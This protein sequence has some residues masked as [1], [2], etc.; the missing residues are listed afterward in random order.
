MKKLIKGNLISFINNYII[1]G[2][3]FEKAGVL[4]IFLIS[5]LGNFYICKFQKNDKD[6]IF[7]KISFKN[8]FIRGNNIEYDKKN[9]FAISS[10]KGEIIIFDI[11]KNFSNLLKNTN[12]EIITKFKIENNLSYDHNW[13]KMKFSKKENNP[14]I[15]CISNN[16]RKLIIFDY[17]KKIVF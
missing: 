3:F 13:V 14:K 4:R 2:F 7:Y 6:F 8:F 5:K 17:E 9:N 11:E 1:N 15:F 10:L 12:L 16:L